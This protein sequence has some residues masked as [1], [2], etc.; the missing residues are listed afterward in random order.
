MSNQY[1]QGYPEGLYKKFTFVFE[2]HPETGNYSLHCPEWKCELACGKFPGHSAYGLAM[3]I[4]GHNAEE[5]R[6][7]NAVH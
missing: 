2:L 3:E 5:M 7:V 6:H 4:A 1:E